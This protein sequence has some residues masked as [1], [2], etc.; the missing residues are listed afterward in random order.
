MPLS[1]KTREIASC[2]SKTRHAS[3]AAALKHLRGAKDKHK[4][5]GYK[6]KPYHCEFCNG[7]HIGHGEYK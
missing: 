3:H 6:I 2:K 4:R 5:L 7:W 1:K